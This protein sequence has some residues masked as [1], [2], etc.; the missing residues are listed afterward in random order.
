MKSLLKGGGGG[1]IGMIWI[2]FYVCTNIYFF[3]IQMSELFGL[4]DKIKICEI[5]IQ[6]LSTTC[7]SSPFIFIFF[8][9]MGKSYFNR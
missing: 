5:I 3:Q 4:K 7:K 2:L 8:I 1:R 6:I 9:F